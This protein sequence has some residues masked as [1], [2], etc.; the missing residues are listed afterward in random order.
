MIDLLDGHHIYLGKIVYGHILLY[1]YALDKDGDVM[2]KYVFPKRMFQVKY[3]NL[4]KCTVS[5][6]LVWSHKGYGY[7]MVIL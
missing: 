7:A 5:K 1:G 3:A 4:G 2:A 6:M